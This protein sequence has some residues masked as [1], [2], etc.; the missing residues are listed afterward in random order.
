MRSSWITRKGLTIK[1]VLERIEKPDWADK[2]E[3]RFFEEVMSGCIPP[4]KAGWLTNKGYYLAVS[5]AGKLAFER[6][7]DPAEF[8]K[9][10][11][12][13][14][15]KAW[16]SY[17]FPRPYYVAGKAKD[18]IVSEYRAARRIGVRHLLGRIVRK[19]DGWRDVLP[20]QSP[21]EC[22]DTWSFL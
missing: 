1:E 2:S 9:E 13:H 12:K 19:P 4:I 22:D 20:V 16:L 18:Q 8:M 5:N 7:P 21:R 15:S 3:T 14:S 11:T 10:A 6:Y 17:H